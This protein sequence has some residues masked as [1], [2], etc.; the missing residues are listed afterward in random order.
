MAAKKVV[1]LAAETAPIASAPAATAAEIVASP[2][3]VEEVAAPQPAPVVQPLRAL[4][5]MAS[6]A[7]GFQKTQTQVTANMEKAMKTVE[8]VV[9]FG[10]GN[11]EAA[12]KSGQIWTAGVQDLGKSFA[13]TAQA[14]FDQTM[15]TWKALSGVK[16]LKDAFDLQSSLAR[17]SMETFVAETGKLTDAS[18]KLT[19][20]ALAPL[21]ARMTVAVEKFGRAAV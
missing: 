1:E 9:A 17:S 5:T 11:M 10:Q 21:T 12:I 4:P 18:L 3:A 20:Q 16:S 8:E 2:V 6:G 19:E 13:A 15:S 7:A 14:Q